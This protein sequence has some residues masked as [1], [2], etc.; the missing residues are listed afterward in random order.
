[1]D[2]LEFHGPHGWLGIF[3]VVVD[4]SKSPLAA[5]GVQHIR[6]QAG[7]QG[8][9]GAGDSLVEETDL[10]VFC[11][12][13][14]DLADGGTAATRLQGHEVRGLDIQIR[15]APE[16]GRIS[17]EG[18]IVQSNYRTLDEKD[19]MYTW[20]SQFGFWVEREALSA[21]RNVKWVN[22]YGR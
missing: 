21:V 8:F 5:R 14:L 4:T 20:G 9:S 12:G 6:Y 22:H 15:Q 1:V 13:L 2:T 11:K 19:G 18:R 16:L 17:V 3:C 10:R 7:G